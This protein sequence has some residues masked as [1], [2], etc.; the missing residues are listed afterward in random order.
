MA[1]PFVFSFHQRWLM[2]TQE[3][4]L[5]LITP[6]NHSV[7]TTLFPTELRHDKTE[8]N[9]VSTHEAIVTDMVDIRNNTEI[10]LSIFYDQKQAKNNQ[11][12]QE[13]NKN[14]DQ[15]PTMDTSTI[16]QNFILQD[17]THLTAY[18]YSTKI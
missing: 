1:I 11:T 14:T 12:K 13:T 8:L 4:R 10:T 9:S 5:I 2:I 15:N 7:D 18:I 17:T 3:A 6:R 16:T